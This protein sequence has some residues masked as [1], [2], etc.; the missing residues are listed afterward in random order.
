[1]R[2]VDTGVED[3][4]LDMAYCCD[5]QAKHNQ[6]YSKTLQRLFRGHP[7]RHLQCTDVQCL[8]NGSKKKKVVTR[9]Y[10][11]QLSEYAKHL[12]PRS[13]DGTGALGVIPTFSRNSEERTRWF[14]E[15]L[16]LDFDSV[17]LA[18]VMPLIGFLEED[19]IYVYLD[20]GTTG[21]GVHLYIFPSKSLSQGEAHTVLVTVAN[22][23]KSL[24]LPY[25]ESMPSSASGP[26]K[27]ILL[28]YRG[29]AEDGLGANP[30]ID[31]MNGTQIPLY[32]AESEIFRTEVED[33]R[34]LVETLGDS[35]ND[36]KF[37]KG[38][39]YNPIYINTYSEVLKA[40]NAECTR[41]KEFWVEG[42]RQYLALGLTAY[43]ISIGVTDEKIREDIKALETASSN[44]EIDSRMKA[45]DGTV[46]K[47]V[48]GERIAWR[49]F[50][51]LADVEPPGANKV[52]AWEVLL[53]L[54]ILED[55]LRSLLPFKGMGG[56]TDLDVLDSLIEVGRKYGRLHPEGVEISIS[57]RDLALVA[58][59]SNTTIINSLKRLRTAGWVSRSNHGVG[60]NSGS[61]VLLIDDED[62]GPR[63]LVTE[64][65]DEEIMVHIP[66]FRWGGGK[67][68]KMSRPILQNLQRLQPCT[69]A[70]LAR[71][72]GRKSRD[73]RNPLNHLVEY[74]L[75]EYDED[76]NTYFLPSN[77]ED[78]LLDVLITN[79]TLQTDFKHKDR[80]ERERKAF[81]A[82][83]ALRRGQNVD[84]YERV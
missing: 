72:M 11:A 42:K 73:L 2:K 63:N 75:V 54:Q 78:R 30:L 58:R 67:L 66:R 26:S 76:S 27:G 13:F 84:S 28:P 80:F 77:A 79:G 9:K 8:E 22:L 61:V 48:K 39:S 25:P 35:Q 82:R 62:V 19:R 20:R 1:M 70:E 53:K 64:N 56:F 81:R 5:E 44:P 60:T 29:A 32:E 43:G 14:V 59:S 71:A 38:S 16:A 15:F 83:I 12:D 18:D 50:Y 31:P 3:T 68:G 17:E 40:W 46:K 10:G 4:T 37:C 47:Y 57:T 49:K 33:L 69:R 23:S 74:K 6:L 7:A 51:N 52:I 36:N 21:R 45:V 55:Q 34:N 24:K 65:A 41:L